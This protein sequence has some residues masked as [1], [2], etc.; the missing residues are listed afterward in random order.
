M[1]STCKPP[2]PAWFTSSTFPLSFFFRF[3]THTL[4]CTAINEERDKQEKKKKKNNQTNKQTKKK[5]YDITL[6][7]SGEWNKQSAHCHLCC[8]LPR[9]RKEKKNKKKHQK[10]VYI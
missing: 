8:F 4:C 10:S 3:N 1:A 2:L 5:K 6:L 9:E 7:S